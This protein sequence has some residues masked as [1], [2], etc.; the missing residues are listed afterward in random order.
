MNSNLNCHVKLL[1]ESN[2]ISCNFPHFIR[3][4]HWKSCSLKKNANN[5]LYFP[6]QSSWTM[7][8]YFLF[9]DRGG[10]GGYDFRRRECFHS[11]EHLIREIYIFVSDEIIV[12]IFGLF[13]SEIKSKNNL[14]IL[15]VLA[16]SYIHKHKDKPQ[17]EPTW[18]TNHKTHFYFM[19]SLKYG[20]Y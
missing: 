2:C 6:S 20:L 7:I 12:S 19:R 1:D 16:S 10:G 17:H 15:V 3:V 13:S 5:N 9:L 18:T 4:G 14:S 8:Y 11:R